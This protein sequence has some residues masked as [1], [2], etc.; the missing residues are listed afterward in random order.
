MILPELVTN[1]TFDL[2]TTGT[3]QL[4]GTKLVGNYSEGT[5]STLTSPVVLISTF[6]SQAKLKFSMWMD[7]DATGVPDG[8]HVEIDFNGAGFVV[9]PVS[10]FSIVPLYF[11]I[12]S[13]IWNKRPHI[14]IVGRNIFIF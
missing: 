9:V 7:A 4:F 12:G 11:H 2:T 1:G 6:A 8:G 10:K 14:Y 3:G 5:E 13:V